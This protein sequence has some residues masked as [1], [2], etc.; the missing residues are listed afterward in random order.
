[1]L[2][3]A[4]VS[5]NPTI[6]DVFIHHYRK[7]N[8][9]AKI[10]ASLNINR[11]YLRIFEDRFAKWRFKSYVTVQFFHKNKNKNWNNFEDFYVMYFWIFLCILCTHFNYV[12]SYLR[13][14]RSKAGARYCATLNSRFEMEK[15]Q[16]RVYISGR[17]WTGMFSRQRPNLYKLVERDTHDKFIYRIYN[18]FRSSSSVVIP[19]TSLLEIDPRNRVLMIVHRRP[20]ISR[21]RAFA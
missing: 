12:I 19:F 7:R 11:I 17:K 6:Y 13:P 16:N 10:Y 20:G 15:A 9:F 18:E 5:V 2:N 4:S 8:V 14:S 21:P 1:M 3:P